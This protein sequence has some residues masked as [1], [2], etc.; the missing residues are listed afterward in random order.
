MKVNGNTINCTL[1][2]MSILAVSLPPFENNRR[3]SLYCVAEISFQNKYKRTNIRTVYKPAVLFA[4]G[5]LSRA[6]KENCRNRGLYF[7]K[8]LFI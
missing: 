6:G 5:D 2:P 7:I 8:R 4:F 3:Q 1:L